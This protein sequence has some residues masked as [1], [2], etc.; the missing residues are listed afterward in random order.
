MATISDL[1]G[2][3][4]QV[5]ASALG[6]G[7]VLSTRRLKVQN[8][9]DRIVTTRGVFYCKTYSKPWY[10][11][12]YMD[13]FPVVHEAAAYAVLRDQGLATPEVVWAATDRANPLG[14]P[15]L[16]L[17]E[18]PGQTL[19]DVLREGRE[20]R[21]LLYAAGHYLRQMHNRSFAHAGYVTSRDGSA[22][23]PDPRKW[24]HRIWVV[25]ALEVQ[26]RTRW[27]AAISSLGPP[28]HA[29]LHSRLDRLQPVLAREYASPRMIHVD[30][31]AHQFY[32]VDGAV[33]GVVDMEVAS[34]GDAMADLVK[35]AIEACSQF[36]GHAWWEP[37]FAGYG[38]T[39][40]F[41]TFQLRMLCCEYA[42]F[43]C[44][45]WEDSYAAILAR[46]AATESW[47][48]LLGTSG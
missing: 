11:E 12:P 21:P 41:Q 5:L 17:T 32:F 9:V 6:L 36:P 18:V 28:L 4:V 23:P 19:K 35:F 7:D 37:F 45:G 2:D 10:G 40:D 43:A 16:L 47:G 38:G 15:F 1:P 46:L 31:H 3:G 13:P 8:D 27:D 44:Q 25:E 30:C 48:D 34:A 14:R 22:A 29:D 20:V 24:R 26:A 33:T 42:E 39:P